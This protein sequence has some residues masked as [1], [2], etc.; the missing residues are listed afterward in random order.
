MFYQYKLPRHCYPFPAQTL[1]KKSLFNDAQLYGSPEGG[2]QVGN[3]LTGSG[4]N[5]KS[6]I[7]A[8]SDPFRRVRTSERSWVGLHGKVWMWFIVTRLHYCN[9]RGIHKHSTSWGTLRWPAGA[10]AWTALRPKELTA[11]TQPA[12]TQCFQLIPKLDEL[13][14]EQRLNDHLRGLGLSHILLSSIL[15]LVESH[16]AYRTMKRREKNE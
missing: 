14:I 4:L 12:A 5:G 3:C 13:S 9:P 16:F 10:V 11:P 6:L 7:R 2:R 1:P 8:T 15:F